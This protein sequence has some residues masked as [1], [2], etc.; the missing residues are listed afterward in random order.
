MQEMQEMQEMQVLILGSG[1]APGGGN[2]NPLQNSCWE[3]P[4]NRGAWWATC[5]VA[6]PCL[7]LYDPMDCCPPGSL[8]M[9]FSRHGYWSGLPFPSPG[10]LPNPRIEP[11]SPALQADSLPTELQGKPSEFTQ[12]ACKDKKELTMMNSDLSD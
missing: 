1:R 4:M 12:V 6:Q 2:G 3:N 10:D 5:L 8:S 11:W 9:R 7:T